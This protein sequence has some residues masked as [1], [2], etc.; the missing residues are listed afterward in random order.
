MVSLLLGLL[1]LWVRFR[2]IKKM[3]IKDMTRTEKYSGIFLQAKNIGA[4]VSVVM[5][6]LLCN[7]NFALAHGGQHG[8]AK[9]EIT[10]SEKEADIK[11]LESI[12]SILKEVMLLLTSL[13]L[14]NYDT[15]VPSVKVEFQ[16]EMQIHHKEHSYEAE[17][18][19][20]ESQVPATKL[21]V[22]V[23]THGGKTH[24][25]VRYIDKPEEMF[26]VDVAISATEPLIE[27]IHTRTGLEK[28]AIRVALVYF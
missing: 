3:I 28:E 7:F 16:D 5:I 12:V 6:I 15:V 23:E 17:N 9:E 4:F 24:V 27:A 19:V 2:V 22:E 10:V 13:K 26:F 20:S 8:E 18:P 25:H 21:I 11:K 14:G 1:I